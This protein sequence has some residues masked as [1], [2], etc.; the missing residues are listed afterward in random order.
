MSVPAVFDSHVRNGDP[1][2]IAEHTLLL[3][4]L[5]LSVRVHVISFDAQRQATRRSVATFCGVRPFAF[6][7]RSRAVV[8][9]VVAGTIDELVHHDVPF[10]TVVVF[11]CV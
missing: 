11:I 8:Y 6:D 10:Q 4:L 2:F 9:G 3:A 5:A 7:A 1:D